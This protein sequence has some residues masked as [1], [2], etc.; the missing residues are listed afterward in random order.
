MPVPYGYGAS[1]GSK[2][3]VLDVAEVS[4]DEEEYGQYQKDRVDGAENVDIWAAEGHGTLALDDED[5]FEGG[6]ES[7]S[8]G[9]ES[10]DEKEVG[11]LP[12]AWEYEMGPK[13][14]TRFDE[15]Y[16]ARKAK[17]KKRIR[18]QI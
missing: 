13:G 8:E 14:R 15:F 10:D 6:E 11:E 2:F 3:A 16:E 9:G 17:N 18:P 5:Q 12:I 1:S 7:G 4:E